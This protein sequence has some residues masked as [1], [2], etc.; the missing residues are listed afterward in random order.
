MATIKEQLKEKFK[1]LSS[2]L[3]AIEKQFGKGAIM[4]LGGADTSDIP[5][6]PTGSVGLDLALGVGGLPRG[7]VVE[8]F[9]PESSGKTTL[10]LHAI[11]QAQKAGGICAFIDAEHALDVTYAR[12]LGVRIEDLLVSQPDNGEQALE[13]ADKLVGTGAIDMIVVDSVAALVPKAEIE[14]EMGDAHMGLQARLMSQALRKL[15]AATSRNA[16]CVVF[17]NQLRQ[18]IGVVYGN[19]E[20]TTGGNALKFYAS[21]RLDIRKIGVVKN[22]EQVVGNK[23]RVKVVKNKMA[24]PFRECEFEIL[25]GSGVNAV[26]EIVDLASEAG[27]LEKSGAYYS[28]QG[29]RIAQGRDKACQHMAEHPALVDELREKLVEQRKAENARL[30]AAPTSAPAT[31]ADTA[32][33]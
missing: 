19:P 18:K 6:I 33:A 5:V 27:L 21:V 8:V 12:K 32:A 4:S 25:Y 23:A 17:I 10:T 29:E 30:G 22:G 11:A 28:W 13:I 14:G 2:A 15:T 24:P 9:G 3:S 31:S 16:T 7:R 26:G 1:A 20:T